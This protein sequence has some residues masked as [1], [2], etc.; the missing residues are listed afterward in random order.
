MLRLSFS[1]SENLLSLSVFS[2]TSFLLLE[3]EL[4]SQTIIIS[5]FHATFA[6][7]L[8][9]KNENLNYSVMHLALKVLSLAG[10]QACQRNK[11]K[12]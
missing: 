2:L 12:I 3:Y 5:R 1:L 4:S 8:K 11:E 10:L 7:I 9:H 6:L